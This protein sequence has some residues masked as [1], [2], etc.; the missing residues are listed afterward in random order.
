MITMRSDG[1]QT[2]KIRVLDLT[3]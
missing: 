2:Y 1:L 3:Q